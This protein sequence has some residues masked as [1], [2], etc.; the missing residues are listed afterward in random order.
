M[1]TH[2]LQVDQSREQSRSEHGQA[3]NKAGGITVRTSLMQPWRSRGWKAGMGKHNRSIEQH[4]DISLNGKQKT[5]WVDGKTWNASLARQ[6]RRDLMRH[7][8]ARGRLLPL[9]LVRKVFFAPI[10]FLALDRG[11]EVLVCWHWRKFLIRQPTALSAV[12]AVAAD[13]ASFASFINNR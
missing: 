2:W 5:R 10:N 9:A 6:D 4:G 3:D 8:N 13:A 12:R 7:G 11:W 1:E